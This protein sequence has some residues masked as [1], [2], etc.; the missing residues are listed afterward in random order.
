MNRDRRS[1][2]GSLGMLKD[3]RCRVIP[4]A[5]QVAAASLAGFVVGVAL[6]QA[7]EAAWASHPKVPHDYVD[8]ILSY[9]EFE[10]YCAWAVDDSIS[11][12]DALRFIRLSIDDSRWADIRWVEFAGEETGCDAPVNNTYEIYF[13]TDNDISWSP[14]EGAGVIGCAYGLP[15]VHIDLSTGDRQWPSFEVDLDTYYLNGLGIDRGPT[16]INHEVG[17]VLG[18][19]DDK[20]DTACAVPSIMHGPDIEHQC[21]DVPTDFDAATVVTLEPGGSTGW[22]NFSKVW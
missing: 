1:A 10:N 19:D 11:Q 16:L 18:L 15:P 3:Q 6:R 12:P 5:L 22:T 9:G 2:H 20:E 13:Y 21:S 14:C 17:H 4:G 8:S 7:D